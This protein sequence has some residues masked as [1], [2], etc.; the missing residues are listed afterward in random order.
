MIHSVLLL[1]L[2]SSFV[3]ISSS[4]V[5]VGVSYQK[6]LDAGSTQSTLVY[7]LPRF[8]T[9]SSSSHFVVVTPSAHFIVTTMSARFAVVSST[10]LV[11]RFA[12]AQS[13][14]LV[15]CFAVILLAIPFA[16]PSFSSLTHHCI[17]PDLHVSRVMGSTLPVWRLCQNT[18]LSRLSPS[19]DR[20]TN[21]NHHLTQT[22]ASFLTGLYAIDYA[23]D[24]EAASTHQ[25]FYGAKLHQLDLSL[26]VTAVKERKKI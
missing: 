12:V 19:P 10:R 9:A 4:C 3:I 15:V 23:P 22:L 26:L 6:H 8:A 11:I 18:P 1:C 21:S 7:S 14:R 24:K 20:V 5:S 13:T 17:S 16:S 2:T 25:G